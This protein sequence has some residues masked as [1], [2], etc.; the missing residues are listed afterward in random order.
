MK[1]ITTI[2]LNFLLCLILNSIGVSAQ[3]D[4]TIYYSK[5][6]KVTDS[7]SNAVYYS[8]VVKKENDLFS[9]MD[10]ALE[11]KRW[12]PSNYTVIRREKDNL[13][14]L[15]SQSQTNKSKNI[16][17]K[18]FF[19]RTDSGYRIKDYNDTILIQEGESKLIFPLIK[20]G[21]W[22][23]YNSSTGKIST[24]RIY[25][26]DQILNSNYYITDNE[27]IEEPFVVVEK[28]PV[29]PGGDAVLLQD[30]TKHTI[31]P[32]EAKEKN[33]TGRVLVRFA[34]LK[35]GSIGCVSLPK[36]VHPLLDTAAI[37]TVYSLPKQ[38][39]PGEQGG[40]KVN[41]WYMLPVT[42]TNSNSKN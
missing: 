14:R 30:I 6:S 7:K 2:R 32:E 4:T 16:I 20:F 41:V 33:I 19:I 13:F 23:F 10:Y 17:I 28:M 27:Y 8:H 42:F 26:D 37:K 5:Y 29:Y 38:F 25:N 3:N 40:R 11:N 1:V 35:D 22:R 34:I 36:K 9:M 18:R 39:K 24:E 31:Y 15:T 12:I 21:T